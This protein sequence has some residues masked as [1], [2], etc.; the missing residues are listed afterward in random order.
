MLEEQVKRIAGYAWFPND[1][2][3]SADDLRRFFIRYFSE[4]G[5]TQVT[6]VELFIDHGRPRPLEK[7]T[8]WNQLLEAKKQGKF[9]MICVPSLQMLSPYPVDTLSIVRALSAGPHPIETLFMYENLLSSHPDFHMALSFHFTIEDYLLD[10]KKRKRYM[11]KLFMRAQIASS[12]S[13]EA[14]G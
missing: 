6:L 10:L 3:T 7:R 8:G 5:H 9:D 11:K 13:V 1:I 14:K 12:S 4:P 2:Q